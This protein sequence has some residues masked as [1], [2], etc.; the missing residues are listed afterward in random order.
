MGTDMQEYFVHHSADFYSVSIPV[1]PCEAARIDLA[2][3]RSRLAN[4]FPYVE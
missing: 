3:P 1:S 4:G 2:V